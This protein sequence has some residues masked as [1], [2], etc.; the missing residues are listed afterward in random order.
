[1]TEFVWIGSQS[2]VDL[3]FIVRGSSQR[4]GLPGTVDRTVPI[5]GRNGLWDHGAD[6]GA[7]TFLLDCAFITRDAFE[8]QQRVMHLA[9]HLIDSNGKP[10]EQTLRFRER[11]GQYFIARYIG[12]FDIQRIVGTGIFSLSLMASDPF[13]YGEEQIF[14][15]TITASPFAF[16]I[17]SNGN[18]RTEPVIVLT[19]TGTTALNGFR[20]RNEYE[21][22][23]GG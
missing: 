20:L 10:R 2:N 15:T 11:P 18:V 13:A 9:A 12:S 7:R 22:D 14:E 16:T 3:G 4:P 19:N 21:V 23:E 5:P 1:M 8:L 17:I 6:L